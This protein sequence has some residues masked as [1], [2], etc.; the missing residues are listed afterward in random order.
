MLSCSP[1]EVNEN[2]ASIDNFFEYTVSEKE[3]R[4]VA[5]SIT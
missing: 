3:D 1:D 2:S 4:E 5:I